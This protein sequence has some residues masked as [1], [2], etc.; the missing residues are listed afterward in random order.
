[1]MA[2]TALE[3]L[4]ET[5]GLSE[6]QLEALV[7]LLPQYEEAQAAAANATDLAA[8]AMEGAGAAA[9]GAVTDVVALAKAQEEAEKAARDTAASFFNLGDG[10]NDASVSLGDWIG[11]ME[12]QA[13]ALRN[14][15][16]N[17]QEAADRGLRDGL[18]RA[19]Q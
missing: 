15:R 14:F 18:I 13:R 9:G 6:G 10:L 1:E 2:A 5:E 8:G 7:D 4:A 16:E 11:Q 19:L 12:D 17:A 3:R